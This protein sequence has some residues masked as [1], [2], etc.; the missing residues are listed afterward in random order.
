VDPGPTLTKLCGS[1]RH[2][3]HLANLGITSVCLRFAVIYPHFMSANI[4]HDT[5]TAIC[6][7]HHH[8]HHHHRDHEL[9]RFK[10]VMVCSS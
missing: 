8:H 5:S 2:F 1:R 7:L 4:S 3:S 10:Y 6:C 9:G